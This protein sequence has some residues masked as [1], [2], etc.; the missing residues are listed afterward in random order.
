MT[1]AVM[2]LASGIAMIVWR[3]CR[4]REARAPRLAVAMLLLSAASVWV[5]TFWLAVVAAAGQ[6]GDPLRA[7]GLL[8]QQL[9]G[10]QVSW[11]RSLPLL[12]WLTVFGGRAAVTVVARRWA[13]VP[14]RE[15]LAG[16]TDKGVF[17]VVADL[18][19]P[20]VTVGLLRPRVLVDAAFFARAKDAELRVVVD[21]ELA[22]VRGRHAFVELA[23]AMLVAP[24]LPLRPARDVYDCV[25]RHLEA[26]A[27][28]AAV[29]VYG[30]RL[31]GETLA[32]I[33]LAHAPTVGLGAAGD[34]VWRVRRLVTPA[35]QASWRDLAVLVPLVA[36]MAVAVAVGVADAAWALGPVRYPDVCLA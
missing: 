35:R 22:H 19:T 21:H 26:L 10:G 32:R 2:L 7:C 6:V 24:L 4:S 17:A 12:A 3:P 27:D 29:R 34:C 8:W 30:R 25:R 18:G 33:A 20:A 11:A 31:V 5:A 16:G 14:L 28:D 9:L 36:M 15:S 1:H 13:A 23:A